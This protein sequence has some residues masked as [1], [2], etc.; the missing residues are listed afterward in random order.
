MPTTHRESGEVDGIP[1]DWWTVQNVNGTRQVLRVQIP[2]GD[3]PEP[4]TV[5]L[6]FPNELFAHPPT[7]VHVLFLGPDRWEELESRGL[8]IVG[9][10]NQPQLFQQLDVITRRS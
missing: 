7:A 1:Y 2:T 3:K 9:R 6:L 4:S 8:Q 10:E 5:F